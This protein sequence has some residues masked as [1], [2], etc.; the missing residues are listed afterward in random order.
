MYFTILLRK[1]RSSSVCDL[2]LC[3]SEHGE[4]TMD[5]NAFYDFFQGN[6]ERF[7]ELLMPLQAV[8]LLV[9]SRMGLFLLARR[10]GLSG[11]GTVWLPIGDQIMLVR[12]SDQ[13][14]C[15]FAG[16][17]KY[18]KLPVI[19]TEMA[20][21]VSN[22]LAMGWIALFL[23]VLMLTSGTV[24]FALSSPGTEMMAFFLTGVVLLLFLLGVTILRTLINSRLMM[25][26]YRSCQRKTAAT[27]LILGILF[28]FLKP[29][30]LFL[31]AKNEI[32]EEELS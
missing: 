2:G 15:R 10:R 17:T 22:Y 21:V 11:A 20:F 8:V 12:L 13:Y 25:D 26:V 32:K 24:V 31:C 1:M 14:R 3:C 5:L 27:W 4:T 16:Q 6:T 30:F 18:R 29:V 28:P 23:M 19:V 9:L 7:L